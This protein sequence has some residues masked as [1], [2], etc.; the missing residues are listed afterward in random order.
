MTGAAA[1]LDDET[2]KK[3]IRQVRFPL[4][5][6]S[7]TEFYF[8]DCNLPRDKFPRKTIHESDDGLVSLAL[9]CSFTRMRGHLCL[10][11]VKADEIPEDTVKVVADALRKSTA[12][13]ISDDGMK[14]G[15]IAELVKA[16]DVIEQVD[17]RT[18]SVSPLEYDV[19]LE[20][21]EFFFCQFAKVNSVR[22][23]RHVTDKKLFCGTALVEFSS[24]E[25]AESILKKSLVYSGAELELKTKKAF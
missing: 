2:V 22:L 5:K 18:I 15:R 3:V 25:E 16:E 20:D 10:G 4:P 23:P 9:I 17:T 8:S 21:I 12:L 1:E 7:S 14:V 19:K 6:V 11:N 24:Q 13:K